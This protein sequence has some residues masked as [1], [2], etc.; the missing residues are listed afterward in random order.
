MPLDLSKYELSRLTAQD[1]KSLVASMCTTLDANEK[2][3]D[4]L[5]AAPRPFVVE[6]LHSLARHPDRGIRC[7]AVEMLVVL[8]GAPAVEWIDVLLNDEDLNIR[9]AGCRLLAFIECDASIERLIR[10]LHSDP[11]GDV[12]YLAADGLELIGDSSAL[13]ALKKACDD[14]GT[15][16]EGRPIRRLALRAIEAISRR[17]NGA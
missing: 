1:V 16:F 11:A 5:A 3:R 6:C 13:P 8:E 9:C 17:I 4:V 7:N 14:G 12:R 15:D 2:V 10:C